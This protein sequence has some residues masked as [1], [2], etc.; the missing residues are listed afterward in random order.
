[1]LIALNIPSLS[2]VPLAS[3]LFSNICSNKN[4][5]RTIDR[6]CFS[7][8]LYFTINSLYSDGLSHTDK[9][10]KGGIIRIYHESDGR[11]GKS[12]SRIAVW[13]LEACRVMTNSDPE[14]RKCRVGL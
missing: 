9:C 3:I 8:L 6:S 11:I 5:I 1:M 13:H 4:R 2:R 12:V 14:G 7:E 10:N